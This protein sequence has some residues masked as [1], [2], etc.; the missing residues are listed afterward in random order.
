MLQHDD[1]G[2]EAQLIVGLLRVVLHGGF[3]QVSFCHSAGIFTG[4]PW[5]SVITRT[6]HAMPMNT[7]PMPRS[8]RL[9]HDEAEDQHVR[10]DE[11]PEADV[12][13][14]LPRDRDVL[15][16]DLDREAGEEQ[17]A[18]A[19]VHREQA[20]VGAAR[21]ERD[22]QRHGDGDRVH[23][24]AGNRT[25]IRSAIVTNPEVLYEVATASPV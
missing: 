11:E 19:P 22:Q 3:V 5:F 12:V 20:V 6:L 13:P 1:V 23:Q 24:H 9:R 7:M 4:M 8:T 21:D 15:E 17:A 2:E 10:G 14:V 25:R 16:D 18:P